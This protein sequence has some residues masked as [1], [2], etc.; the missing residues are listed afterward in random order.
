MPTLTVSGHAI[1][2][3]DSGSPPGSV[4]GSAAA[5]GAG[6]AAGAP[7]IALHSGGL[8]SRQ[9]SKLAALLAPRHRVLAP[10]FTGS[11][12]SSPWPA[13]APYHHSVEVEVTLAL[14]A[15][16]DG[17]V[18]LVGH[19][20]GG[21]VALRAALG[22]P[23]RVLSLGLFEPVAFGLLH[24]AGGTE[25]PGYQSD[26]DLFGSAGAAPGGEVWL[27]RFIDWWQGAG[28]W[29]ALPPP[30]KAQ[31]L[32][33][34]PKVCL[35]VSSLTT[36]RLAAKDLASL[37]MPAL[38]LRSERSPLAAR[39]TCELLAHALPRGRLQQLDGTGHLAPVTHAA[40]VNALLAEHLE[41]S[42]RP[43]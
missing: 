16:L 13:G 3:T 7:V 27:R 38:V 12:G 36:D 9:W 18:H 28:A 34:G 33:V 17:P 31:F 35:E 5:G 2:F 15:T 37:D 19:S 4:P 26:M 41:A 6:T 43:R 29:D 11:G 24:E 32:A 23:A 22:A 21:L 1:H 30:A 25:L 20:F 10:D 14:L 39:R 42:E 8:S 40:A